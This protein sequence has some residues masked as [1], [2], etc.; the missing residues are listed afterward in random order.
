M[1]IQK[2]VGGVEVPPASQK[3]ANTIGVA[4]TSDFHSTPD[5]LKVVSIQRWQ[6]AGMLWN[7]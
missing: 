3:R 6:H 2:H 5:P 7:T 4:T 1:G